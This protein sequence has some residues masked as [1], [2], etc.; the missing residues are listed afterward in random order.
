M[1]PIINRRR[2]HDI[3]TG[4]FIERRKRQRAYIL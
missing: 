3:G 2:R 4:V 1:T